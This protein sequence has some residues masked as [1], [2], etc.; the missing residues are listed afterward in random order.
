MALILNRTALY[1]SD[2]SSDNF[3]VKSLKSA[4][5]SK[6]CGLINLFLFYLLRSHVNK[7]VN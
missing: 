7:K 3:E 2:T 5:F 1:S 6:L 4:S